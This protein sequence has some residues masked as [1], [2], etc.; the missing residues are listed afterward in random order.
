MELR[1]D[2]SVDAATVEVDGPTP[3]GRVDGSEQLD[4]D[5]FVKFDAEDRILVYEFHHVRRHGVKLDD[6]D[7][8]DELRAVFREAGFAERGWSAP[9]PTR[10]L[11]RP[12]AKTA[13]IIERWRARRE[14]GTTGR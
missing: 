11:E 10:R 12:P 1:Y 4:Q 2:P 8:R 13:A 14:A 6:L 3:P 9:I 7:H 5:R